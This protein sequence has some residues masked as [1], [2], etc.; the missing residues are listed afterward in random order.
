MFESSITG[1]T[2]ASKSDLDFWEEIGKEAYEILKEHMQK[3]EEEQAA[4][5]ASLSLSE[6]DFWSS[7]LDH[8]WNST[9]SDIR[10]IS[11]ERRLREEEMPRQEIDYW[12]VHNSKFDQTTN[13]SGR[14]EHPLRHYL[15]EDLS[16]ETDYYTP[17]P[18]GPRQPGANR[19][20]PVPRSSRG[21]PPNC[22][23]QSSL[24]QHFNLRLSNP[25]APH[26]T[27]FMPAHHP[28]SPRHLRDHH[29]A[30]IRAP[31]TAPPPRAYPIRIRAPRAPRAGSYG[32]EVLDGTLHSQ[33]RPGPR[34]QTAAMLIPEFSGRP[35]R[36]YGGHW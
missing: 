31:R 22:L 20:P 25:F 10:H 2:K 36:Y 15:S 5:L 29:I 7:K 33:M 17:Q 23:P 18:Q 11:S 9:K 3:E 1:L 13:R 34:A 12:N 28:H 4:A 8:D 27:Y 19:A 30:D 6:V 32:A 26:H 35:A 21:P 24:E 14:A 16:G